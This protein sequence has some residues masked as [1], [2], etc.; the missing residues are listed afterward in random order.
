MAN[1]KPRKMQGGEEG[2]KERDGC[3]P[4][5]EERK[6]ILLSTHVNT[7]TKILVKSGA[8]EQV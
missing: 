6:K 1:L 2:K 8:D 3:E 7:R 4:Y 5:K